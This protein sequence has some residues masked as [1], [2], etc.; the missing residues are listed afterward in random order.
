MGSEMCIRDRDNAEIVIND[1][2][3]NVPY[4]IDMSAYESSDET[5]TEED[6]PTV[7][8]EGDASAEGDASTEGTEGDA[9]TE[10]DATQ[11]DGSTEGE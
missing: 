4:N 9:S 7:E 3:E 2:P 6:F 1:M 8:G 11:G 10:G 5:T